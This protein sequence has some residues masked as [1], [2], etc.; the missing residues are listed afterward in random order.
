MTPD[1]ETT[2]GIE[3]QATV[4]SRSPADASRPARPVKLTRPDVTLADK[5]VLEQGTIFL[6][7]MQALVRVLLDQHRADARRGLHTGHLRLRLPG[8]AARRP[9]QGDH[10]AAASS[11]PTTALHSSPAST[12]SSRRPPSRAP[13]C[14]TSLPR[15]AYDGVLG[16]WYGKNPGPGPRD[17]RAA[18]RELR[19]HRPPPAARS[20]SSATTRAASPRRCP[21]PP[22]RT[23]AALQHADVL[24]R[25]AAGGPR[26]RPA[27]HRLLAR[28]GPVERAEDRHERRRRGRHRPGLARARRARAA[29]GRVATGAP[30]PPRAERQPA[31]A[32]LARARAHAV[33]RRGSRSR[34][35]YARAQPAQPR[36]AVADRDAWLGIVAAGKTY[37]ELLQALRDLGLDERELERAGIRLLKLGMLWPLDA[38]V[39]REFARG[40]EEI[41][42]VEEKRPVP[43][44]RGQATRSTARPTRPRDRRQARRA[45]ARRC[46]RATAELDADLIARR[47]AA[48]LGR[49]RLASTS[50]RARVERDRRASQRAAP[51]AAA[52]R[53]H[54]VLLL[55]LPAQHARRRTPTARCV[56]A[57]IGC[58][59]M[60]LL[61]A[62]G[63][64]HDHRHHADGRRGRAVGRAW[65][66]SPTTDHF[67]QNIGDG[68]FHHSGSLAHPLRRRR[69][70]SNIT[71]KLLY[72]D[73]VA[74]TGGQDVARPA[75]RPRADA[76]AGA[77]GRQA[78]SS[79]R[80]RSPSATAACTLAAI[81]EVRDRDEL[82]AAQR[83]L[84]TVDGRDG[85][86][87]RPGVR[88]RAAPRCA[89]A[90]R[91]P[92]PPSA[93]TSTS[94]SARAAATAARS[95]TA[96]PCCRSRP[97]SAARRRSTRP[98]ATRTTRASKGDCPSF[99]TVVA[100]RSS[101]QPKQAVR[102]SRPSTLPEPALRV[103]RD[104]FVV[105]MTGIGGTGVVTVV[106]RSSAWPRCSTASTCSGLDQTG[107]RAEGRPGRLRPAHLARARSTAL[108]QGVG[109]RDR[110]HPRLRPARRGQPA[111]TCSTADPER[112]VAVVSTTRGADRR[113][114][115]RHRRALPGARRATLDGDR[116]GH[117]R[118]RAT[119]T[120]TPRRS[121][122]RCSATTCR[123]TRCCSAPPTSAA[124]AGVRRRR[125]SRRSGST[126]RPSRRTSPRSAGAAPWSRAPERRRGRARC[127]DGA[128]AAAGRRAGRGDRRRDRRRAASC[129]GCSRSACRS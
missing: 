86:D 101:A 77:R 27:R 21:A 8:L 2:T 115:H 42:V 79:S 73:A 67:V 74:M 100:G 54:A 125:S 83:E 52:A 122:R 72:N 109:R 89:S 20:R 116:A 51:R 4:P 32:G 30:V 13:S 36:S 120:S 39:V 98:R 59:T 91:P 118:R 129:A 99:L 23:L 76:L 113:D 81:A 43:R 85:A 87:P 17:G 12:R 93:S 68:T 78:R 75:R 114:G 3:T 65:R 18:P 66:R 62:G 119:S 47:V 14:A 95:P 61:N 44:D 82:P 29:A 15:P 7:G 112:T 35:Q 105:R 64:G 25:H 110:P 41:L 10:A 22:R 6:S 9:R 45:A 80:P 63:Q 94:A 46:C 90:A 123:P 107:P 70:A 19:R 58:H 128:R 5:Y 33:R 97:S 111:R 24:P 60:V 121:P 55:G 56:G 104:D 53:A 37:Y 1:I 117:A 92:T 102:A 84:A 11:R 31:G 34:R 40:L 103:P 57:G 124:P 88:R 38:R 26:P 49:P 69:P 48:R 96:C 126:A 16:V 108:E 106:A 71:Y 28:V 50:A 127:G